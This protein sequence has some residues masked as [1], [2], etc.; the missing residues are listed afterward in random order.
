MRKACFVLPAVV[1]AALLAGVSATAVRAQQTFD[2]RDIAGHWERTTPIVSFG[3][4]P[5]GGRD[6]PTV[7]EAPFTPEG[8]RMYEANKP[9]YG[10]RRST[11]RNDP[12]GRCE[13]L[14]LPRQLN[15]EIVEPL[16]RLSIQGR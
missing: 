9:G 10:P 3:N 11:Q 6:N 5:T 16:D 1:A 8:L 14:G 12:L 7:Q 2:P 13:P 15:A 4:V